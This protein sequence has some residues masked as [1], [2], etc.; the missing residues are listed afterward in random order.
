[1]SAEIIVA[2]LRRFLLLLAGGLCVGT[3]V[4]LLLVNHTEDL[5]QLLPFA[6]CGIGL[7]AVLMVLLQPRRITVR[8]C[9]G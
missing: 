5:I 9:K 7:V 3:V 8:R 1:M 6:L 2:R 4:E